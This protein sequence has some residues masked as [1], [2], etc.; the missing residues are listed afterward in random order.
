MQN[1]RGRM[2]FVDR[3][4]LVYRFTPENDHYAGKSSKR[5]GDLRGCAKSFARFHS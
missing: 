5:D 4:P 1:A 2:E 3:R